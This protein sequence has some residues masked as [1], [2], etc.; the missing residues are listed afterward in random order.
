MYE[1]NVLPF[2]MSLSVFTKIT[3]AAVAPLRAMGIRLDT[4]L[5]DWLI[6]AVSRQ[7]ASRHTE[8]VVSHLTGLGF[9]VNLEKSELVPTQQIT[10]LGVQLDSTTM[11]GRL[12]GE[13]IERFLSCLSS[14]QDGDLIPYRTCQR[15]SGFMASAMHLICLGKF[16]ARPFTRGCSLFVSRLPTP[17]TWSE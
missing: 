4:Y 2:G 7:E 3:Q 8:M 14:V 6:S 17:N 16:Y 5:D 15:I 10:F 9:Y 1:Y 12:S 13:R 11:L